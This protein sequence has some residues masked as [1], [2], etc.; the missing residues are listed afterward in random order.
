[1]FYKVLLNLLTQV[2]FK[3]KSYVYTFKFISKRV[4]F[5]Y[6]KKHFSYYYK[7]VKFSKSVLKLL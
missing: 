1:M 6:K 4:F 2:L 5:F 7:E 3:V